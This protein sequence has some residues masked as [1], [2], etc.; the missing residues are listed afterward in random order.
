LPDRPPRWLEREAACNVHCAD[1]PGW[2]PRKDDP[3]VKAALG[4]GADS[5]GV[6]EEDTPEAFGGAVGAVGGIV[7]QAAAVE[8]AGDAAPA[9]GHPESLS[10][11]REGSPMRRQ[12]WPVTWPW[13]KGR[14]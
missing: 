10:Y 5:E 1:W 2:D 12:L 11:H 4:S 9:S 8:L 13:Q 3:G 6:S 14:G 7:A